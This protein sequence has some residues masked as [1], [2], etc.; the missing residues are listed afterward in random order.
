MGRKVRRKELGDVAAI[1]MMVAGGD[2]CDAPNAQ[3]RRRKEKPEDGSVE[4]CGA[5][6]NRPATKV[7]SEV[8]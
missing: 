3:R 8:R 4:G 6:V 7:R 2:V 5:G 1:A